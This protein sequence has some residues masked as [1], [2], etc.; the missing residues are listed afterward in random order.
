M[1]WSGYRK[2]KTNE[3][4]FLRNRCCDYYALVQNG[5]G[6]MQDLVS[7]GET[8]FNLFLPFSVQVKDDK[9]RTLEDQLQGH[10]SKASDA[11]EELQVLHFTKL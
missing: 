11:K 3:G 6:L 10:Y 2:G 8:Y 4:C 9:I 5:E 7:K 1:S